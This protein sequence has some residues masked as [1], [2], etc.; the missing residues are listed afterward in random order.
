MQFQAYN[1][2]LICPD[3]IAPYMAEDTVLGY[4]FHI[5]YPSY[6]GTFLSCIEDLRFYLDGGEINPQNIRFTLGGKEYLLPQLADA[7]KDYWYVMDKA[8]V[9]VLCDTLPE[10]GDHELRVDMQHRIPYA[11]Y[12]GSYLSLGSNETK[13]LAMQKGGTDHV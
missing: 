6:R 9:T 12:G 8:V 13:T 10:P 2:I 5:R 4:R 7:Y 1:R 3:P 11:G